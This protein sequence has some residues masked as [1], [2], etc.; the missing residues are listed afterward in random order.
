MWDE[1]KMEKW[2]RDKNKLSDVSIEKGLST[3]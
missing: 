1:K 3:I 2:L